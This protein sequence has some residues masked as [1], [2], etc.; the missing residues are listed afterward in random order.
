MEQPKLT[1]QSIRALASSQSFQRGQMLWQSGALSQLSIQGKV[2]SA[3]CEGSS[4]PFYQV[5]AELDGRGVRTASCDC[6][7]DWG[8]HCK[9]VIALLLAYAHN[10]RRFAVRRD[11]TESLSA[12]NQAQLLTIVTKLLKD[13]PELHDWIEAALA[14]PSI[15]SQNNAASGKRKK[16]NVDVYRR[17]VRGIMHSLDG[18]RMSEAYWHV[19]GLVNE[20]RSVGQTAMEFLNAG[21]AATALQ[22]LL[23]L[24]E[25]S[26][27]GIEYI[28]DSNGELG[29]FFDEVGE[30]LAEVIL[31]SELNKT[32]QNSLLTD[33]NKYHDQ[34]SD[35]G[36]DGLSIAVNAVRYGW[37]EM[38]SSP[39]SGR[40]G[41]AGDE[42]YEEEDEYEDE[43]E[44]ED[45]DD[46]DEWTESD[47][48]ISEPSIHY[49]SGYEPPVQSLTPLKLRILERQGRIDEYLKLSLSTDSHL[50]YAQKLISLGR[51]SEAVSHA[52]KKLNW[53]DE[54][55]KLAEQ[56]SEASHLK[57]AIRIGEKGLKL[58][59]PKAA[60]GQWLAPIEEEQ[61][62]TK[63]AI[64]A[65][66]VA[67]H[68]TPSLNI[69]QTLKRLSGKN[70]NKLQPEL[71][72]SL[73][74]AWNKQPL[75]EI[76]LNEKQW[77]QAIKV[78]DQETYN[79][80]LIA[81]V[82]EALIPHRPEWVI[83]ITRQQAETLIAKTQT[84]Y[85]AVAAE[86]LSRTKAAYK[87]LKQTDKWQKYLEQLK[88]E[89][90]R[91]P[92]LMPYLNE[93]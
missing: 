35:Y 75:A 64:E 85:Y 9:H 10:P 76:L 82:A 88:T 28:D 13:H 78:A 46:Y 67:F 47:E 57:E 4:A 77:D 7:Y 69:W 40:I 70:W 14:A 71:M 93:L 74:K 54:A 3:L 37:S 80:H 19:G 33:L 12:L 18:M 79:D 66:L 5:S 1:T 32:E 29:G 45:E 16:V 2:I 6:P 8:G 81:Q 20:L 36:I 22:I 73:N 41:E 31:S 92:A 23:T 72:A 55:L 59:G 50:S 48:E 60:L 44:D 52:L 51:V 87:Q 58:E 27:D 68:E 25:E 84:K 38:P 90:K 21:D 63:Q 49:D 43:D 53:A 11:L 17:R 86:W 15:S 83:Q 24:I 39:H 42:E 89:Y 61:G 56:L 62:R 30:M 91:R 65:W 26:H 34:L